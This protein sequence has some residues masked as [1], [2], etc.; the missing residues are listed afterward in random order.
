MTITLNKWTR[1]HE[2]TT[3]RVQFDKLIFLSWKWMRTN[4]KFKIENVNVELKVSNTSIN[5]FLAK[6]VV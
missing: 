2:A 4:S 1:L 6:E 3:D 5:Q